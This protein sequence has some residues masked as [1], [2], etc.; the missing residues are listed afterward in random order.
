MTAIPSRL[1]DGIEPPSLGG[2]HRLRVY[3]VRERSTAERPQLSSP[4]E[5]W[6]LLHGEVGAWDRERFLTLALD[7]SHRLIGSETVSMGT[8]NSTAI[9]PREIF[10][11]LILANA[12][13]FIAAHNHPSGAVTPSAE[14]RAVTKRLSEAGKLLGIPLLDHV[15]LSADSFHSFAEAGDLPRYGPSA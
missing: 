9:H 6:A 5:V 11:G 7:S 13:A 14:D 1:L 3:A 12:A 15:V 4:Q 2:R 10:K 8:L